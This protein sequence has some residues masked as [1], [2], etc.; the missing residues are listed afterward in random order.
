MRGAI[1][2]N[3]SDNLAAGCCTIEKE[4]FGQSNEREL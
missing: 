4:S 3:P 1:M 2:L